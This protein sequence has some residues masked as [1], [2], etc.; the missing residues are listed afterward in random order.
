M[1]WARGWWWGGWCSV[2]TFISLRFHVALAKEKKE[3][4]LV[5]LK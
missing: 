1:S 2:V 3:K 4:G 5:D